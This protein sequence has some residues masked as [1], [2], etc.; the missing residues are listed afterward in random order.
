MNTNKM[1]Q[2]A[3]ARILCWL[4]LLFSF[5]SSG[6]FA[7]GRVGLPLT[8]HEGRVVKHEGYVLCYNSAL[9]NPCWVAWVLTRARG[10]GGAERASGFKADPALKGLC[11]AASDYAGTGYDKGHLCPAADNK[12]DVKAMKASFYMGNICPQA[13]SL[14]R[15]SWK[16]L[17]ERCRDWARRGGSYFIVAGPIYDSAAQRKTIG[18]GRVAV[19]ER[20]FKVIYTDEGN[21]PRAAGFLFKNEKKGKNAE[22]IVTVDDVERMTGYDFFPDLPDSLEKKVEA[23][24]QPALWR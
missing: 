8:G 15:G 12:W 4:V 17:E 3:R 22:S 5:S 21:A 14:N 19:P 10:V 16:R 18:K 6:I 2:A 1:L 7:Q 9:K 11:A 24:V 20:F 23:A 13:P